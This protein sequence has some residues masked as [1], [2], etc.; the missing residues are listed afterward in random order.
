MINREVKKKLLELSEGEKFMVLPCFIS[1]A[2]Y[3][4]SVRMDIVIRLAKM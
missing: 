3:V 2:K 1:T 4:I